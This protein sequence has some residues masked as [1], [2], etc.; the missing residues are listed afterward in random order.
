MTTL[1]ALE[2]PAWVAAAAA[3]TLGADAGSLV[4]ADPWRLLAVPTLRP[5]QVDRYARSRLGPAARA[6][7]PRRQT[8]LVVWLLARAE[9]DGHTVTPAGTVLATLTGL[10]VT[11]PEAAVAAAV[12]TGQVQQH[13]PYLMSASSAAAEEDLA[14]A[15]A[16]FVAHGGNLRLDPRAGSEAAEADPA[17]TGAPGAGP[18]VVPDA[19]GLG[20]AELTELVRGLPAG[21]H[22]VLAD[23][24]AGLGPLPGPGQAFADLLAAGLFPVGSSPASAASPAP[25]A[26][27]QPATGIGELAAAIRSGVLPPVASPDRE[28]VVVA[29]A[30]AAEVAHRTVQLVTDSIPRALGH[31]VESIQVV[32]PA[33]RGAAGSLALN[34]AIKQQINPGPGRHAGFDPGDRVVRVDSDDPA[35]WSPARV[36]VVVDGS[37]DQVVVEEDAEQ[38]KVSP[39]LLRHGWALTVHQSA[40]RRW[41]AVVAVFP[42]ESIGHA[43]RSLVYTAVTRATAHLTVVTDAGPALRQAVALRTGRRRRTRLVSLLRERLADLG[44]DSGGQGSGPEPAEPGQASAEPGQASAGEA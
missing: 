6:D 41:P 36:G 28:V 24:P 15:L 43:D 27:G 34:A 10:G 33:R 8:G 25:Q 12:A 22:L 7:D 1:D 14:D 32:T 16:G 13:G 38:A 5:D 19:A 40:G 23:D 30:S 20:Y 4:A 31:P 18:V 21:A 44:V 3:R 37:A 17:G 39:D 26:S 35:A 9:L 2:L 42:A 29:G 11:D